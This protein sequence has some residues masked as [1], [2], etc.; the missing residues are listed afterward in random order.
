MVVCVFLSRTTGKKECA[1]Y[2]V[3]KYPMTI[4]RGESSSI[5]RVSYAQSNKRQKDEED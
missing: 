2:A 1:G 5:R 3:E 4:D